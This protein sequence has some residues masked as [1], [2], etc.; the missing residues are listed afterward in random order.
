MELPNTQHRQKYIESVRALENEIKSATDGEVSDVALQSAQ[1][2]L[3]KLAKK[4]QEDEA[5]GSAIYKLYEL[6]ALIYYFDGKD[7]K[8]M[9]FINQAIDSKGG[10]YPKADKLKQRLSAG[11]TTGHFI[12]P[13]E[14]RMTKSEKRK[15]LIG[16]EGWLAW[17]VVG[18]FLAIILTIYNF[19]ASGFLTSSDI[20]SYNQYQQGLGNTIQGFTI[21]EDIMI[22][23]Y[24]SLIVIT[25]I[26]LFRRRKSAK[27][28]AI[29]TLIFIA[30]YGVIDYGI[31]SSIFGSSGLLQNA[32]MQSYMSKYTG[33]IGRSIV[34]ALIWVPY[35][36]KSKR[37][38]ATLVK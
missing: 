29:I 13:D 12:A 1:D 5:I 2:E 3:D 7:D 14:S 8:A 17:F 23:I 22:I 33:E 20:D 30:V 9:K 27:T 4:Y 24:I 26:K 6:Q 16:L 18:Q 35:L 38:R 19:F 10:A 28:F 32:E 37:V 36:L 21:F 15:E 11:P 25:L 31:V 34:A